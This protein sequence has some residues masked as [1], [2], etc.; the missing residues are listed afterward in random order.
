MARFLADLGA[1][2]AVGLAPI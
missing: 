1:R 2:H